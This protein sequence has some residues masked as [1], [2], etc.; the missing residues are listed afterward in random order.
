[1]MLVRYRVAMLDLITLVSAA[2][3]AVSR[4]ND[5]SQ[6]AVIA[7]VHG[8]AQAPSGGAFCSGN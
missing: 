5:E 8:N 6:F 3:T 2:C 1:M 4:G 7:Y